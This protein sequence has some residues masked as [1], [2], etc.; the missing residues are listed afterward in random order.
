MSYLKTGENSRQRNISE[1]AST[2]GSGHAGIRRDLQLPCQ[3]ALTITNKS[4]GQNIDQV[5]I[6]LLTESTQLDLHVSNWTTAGES[7]DAGT[8]DIN[9]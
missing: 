5:T 3:L 6:C 4:S 2:E 7:M 9:L 8:N 1:S